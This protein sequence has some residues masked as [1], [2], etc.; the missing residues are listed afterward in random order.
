MVGAKNRVDEQGK[1]GNA[2][3]GDHG[4][5]LVINP[6]GEVS[7]AT[8]I[9]E[10]GVIVGS[11]TTLWQDGRASPLE[12]L[13]CEPLPGRMFLSSANDINERGE[14]AVD[15]T[16]PDNFASR[17]MILTPVLGSDGCEQ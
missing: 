14:I 10:H 16:D 1:R 8:A 3:E 15:A 5:G 12:E 17:A 6:G 2:S 13:L 11:H 9:N 4:V 7:R